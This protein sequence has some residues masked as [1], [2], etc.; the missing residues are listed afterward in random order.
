MNTRQE[1]GLR[2]VKDCPIEQK[3]IVAKEPAY[4][5]IFGAPKLVFRLAQL[6]V[7][8]QAPR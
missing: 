1:T 4:G 2:L 6:A 8:P 3:A 7:N 5:L